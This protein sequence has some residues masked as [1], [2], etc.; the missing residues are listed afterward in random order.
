MFQIV[1]ILLK[2]RSLKCDSVI[3][4]WQKVSNITVAVILRY[5]KININITGCYAGTVRHEIFTD[6]DMILWSDFRA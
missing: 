3:F 5:I 2:K 6:Q 1:V 4:P